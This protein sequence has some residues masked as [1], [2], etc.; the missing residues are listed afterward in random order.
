MVPSEKLFSAFADCAQSEPSRTDDV[1][2]T[3]LIADAI[4]CCRAAPQPGSTAFAEDGVAGV[5]AQ[6]A[7]RMSMRDLDDVD[8]ASLHHPGSVVLAVVF[9]LGGR[10]HRARGVGRPSGVCGI[11]GG[12]NHGRPARRRASPSLARHR[13]GAARSAP[14]VPRA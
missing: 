8:W 5:V 11:S 3:L 6:L 4:A 12:R 2:A 9:A 7:L 14:P 10:G 1:R 13:D